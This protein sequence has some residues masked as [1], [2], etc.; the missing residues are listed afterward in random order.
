MKKNIKYIIGAVL[1][2]VLA[3]SFNSVQANKNNKAENQLLA[4]N[5][6]NTIPKY[7][8]PL[9][10]K[11]NAIE[12]RINKNTTDKEFLKI[13]EEL[14]E[15]DID[16]IFNNVERNE[17]GFITNIEIVVSKQDL[18]EEFSD[19]NPN[20][21]QP[22][23]IK[24]TDD[25]IF[26]GYEFQEDMFAFS[27]GDMTD[28]MVQIQKMMQKQMQML[29]QMQGSSN[30]NDIFAK[31]FGNDP[32]MSNPQKIMQKMMQQMMQDDGSF[33]SNRGAGNRNT[34]SQPKAQSYAKMEKHYIVNGKEMTEE[35]YQKMDKS[36]IRSLQIYQTQVVSKSYGM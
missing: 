30:N 26:V 29:Q 5:E 35:E 36:K 8:I 11:E 10:K 22:I 19:A 23:L 4:M 6:I 1:L 7:A 15:K 25:R 27:N 17:D 28:E 2:I 32:M 13:M 3:F 20:G 33:F 24:I 14:K 16:I 9:N 34:Q 21:I 18:S 12:F 31:F